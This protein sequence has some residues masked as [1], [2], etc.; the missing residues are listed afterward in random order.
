MAQHFYG[1]HQG[2]LEYAYREDLIINATK[3][4]LKKILDKKTSRLYIKDE[5]SNMSMLGE[6]EYLEILKKPD[7]V[8]SKDS[9]FLIHLKF[10]KI[11]GK[12]FSYGKKL[13]LLKRAATI[14]PTDLIANFRLAIEDEKGGDGD[15]AIRHYELALRDSQ[16]ATAHLRDFISTQIQRV[17]KHG[18]QMRCDSCDLT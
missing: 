5:W 4:L 2:S 14:K 11:A 3:D 8:L 7:I 18:P 9:Q 16:I 6:K 1:K 10:A 17:K 12:N 13:E 15:Q